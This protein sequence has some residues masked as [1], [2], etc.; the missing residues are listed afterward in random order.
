MPPIAISRGPLLQIIEQVKPLRLRPIARQW[1]G[2]VNVHRR[3]SRAALRALNELERHFEHQLLLH[4]EKADELKKQW[5]TQKRRLR[6]RFDREAKERTARIRLREAEVSSILVRTS[7]GSA[8]QSVGHAAAQLLLSEIQFARHLDNFRRAKRHWHEQKRLF[9]AG[10]LKSEPAKPWPGWSDVL[11]RLRRVLHAGADRMMRERVAQ[12]LS[13]CL[14]EQGDQDRAIQ[15]LQTALAKNVSWT[16]EPEL[17]NRLG[18]LLL[19]QKRFA[20]ASYA[21]AAVSQSSG[22]WSLRARLGL[23]WARHRLGDDDRALSAVDDVR[24][25]LAGLFDGDAQS[26]AAAADELYVQLLVESEQ[27]LSSTLDPRIREAVETLR[28]S[29]EISFAKTPYEEWVAKDGRFSAIKRRSKKF[30]QCYRKFLRTH[31]NRSVRAV[32][33]LLAGE[34]PV[35]ANLSLANDNFEQCLT[36]AAKGIESLPNEASALLILEF[37][38][39]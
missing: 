24:K 27:P 9:K 38:N 22:S 3:L 25:Q 36:Q 34:Q 2:E 14:L 10:Q 28:A 18:D 37:S 5:A 39:L 6:A 4:G 19:Q 12:L 33:S 31:P 13:I 1:E 30:R 20:Q 7:F 23:A 32:V 17:Q 35:L 16:M 29:R 8:H 26:L 15:V 21:Y 11:T